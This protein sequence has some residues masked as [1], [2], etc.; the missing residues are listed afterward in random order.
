[1]SDAKK[2]NALLDEARIVERVRIAARKVE[3]QEQRVEHQKRVKRADGLFKGKLRQASIEDYRNWLAGFLEK[4]GKLTHCYEYLIERGLD[5]WKV[6]LKDFQIS[7]LFGTESLNIIVPSGIKFL[8][9][10][11]GHNNLYLMDDFSCIGSWVPIYSD[12]HF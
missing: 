4:G 3:R 1:M 7:P 11:L 12:I 2:L 10:E 8:G 6:A 9:G 5:D